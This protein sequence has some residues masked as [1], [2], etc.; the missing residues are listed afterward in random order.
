MTQAA[1]RHAG[2]SKS[3][4]APWVGALQDY[5][6][7]SHLPLTILLFLMPAVALYEVGTILYAS[8]FARHTETRVLAF[9]LMRQ[10]MA[11][12]GATGRYLPALSIVG[13]LLAWHIARRDPWK[14]HIAT[15]GG[16][17]VE[18]ALL[19]FPLLAIANL[20]GQYLPLAAGGGQLSSGI[21]LALGAGIYEELVFRLMAFTLLNILLID[22]LRVEKRRSYVLIVL[23]SS[24]LFAAYH[25]WSPQSA[26]F[27]WGDFVFRTVAGVYFGMVFLTRGLGISCGC[28]AA[29]DIYYFALRAMAGG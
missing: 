24:L 19:A 20:L 15:A 2:H 22:L 29:Y 28:H 25:H 18:S 16:M 27:H 8:D 23:I 7:Q 12:F 11:L 21:V 14:L 9:N 6:W 17:V 4:P 3:A 5:F 10:F 13:I 1:S 26:P